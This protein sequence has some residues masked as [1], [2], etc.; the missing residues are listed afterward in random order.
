MDLHHK[1]WNQEQQTLRKLLTHPEDHNQAIGLFL[2]QHAMVHSGV[3]SNLKLWSFEDEIWRG[4]TEENI[5]RIPDGCEHSIAWIFWHLTR[6]ED[7]TMNLLLA[8]RQQ[9][10]QQEGWHE[11]MGIPFYDTGNAMLQTDVDILSAQIKI[12]ILKEY[13]IAIGRRTR[14]IV[15]RLKATEL[16]QKVTPSRL[17][18]VYDQGAVADGARG[19]LDYWGGLTY[20]GLL[21]MPPTR[22]NFIHQNEAL[23]IKTK[24]LK[25]R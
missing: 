19:V 24:L 22:H 17:Q 25:L 5:R 15:L 10:F 6:I 21:L 13:R 11:K 12:R 18:M 2:R 8:G 3:M 16:T 9:I 4:L 14:E 1:V 7:V 20:A 23:R